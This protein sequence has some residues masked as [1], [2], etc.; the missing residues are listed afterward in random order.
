[1]DVNRLLIT[2][3]LLQSFHLRQSRVWQRVRRLQTFVVPVQFA[4]K[5][6]VILFYSPMDD[7]RSYD[8]LCERKV[9]GHLNL[10]RKISPAGYNLLADGLH[11]QRLERYAAK[12]K[13]PRWW[14][15]RLSG[16]AG[17]LSGFPGRLLAFTAARAARLL[18]L[19]R[20]GPKVGLDGPA[21]TH[22]HFV[23]R[24]GLIVAAIQ[25][26]RQLML[27]LLL[28]GGLRQIRSTLA[29]AMCSRKMS[30]LSPRYNVL[31]MGGCS[32]VGAKH[33]PSDRFGAD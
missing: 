14:P 21:H 27:R 3:D 7:S 15:R 6:A 9:T 23:Q 19:R 1:M 29:S 33:S 31:G 18:V 12:Q 30:R 10:P 8:L 32:L 26:A 4:K 20:V 5:T 28:N 24:G 16:D 25:Q 13:T 17:R 22:D 11:W 2:G